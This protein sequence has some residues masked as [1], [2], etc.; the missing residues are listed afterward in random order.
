MG[1]WN[2]LQSEDDDHLLDLVAD[3]L[4]LTPP[5]V[6][7]VAAAGRAAYTWRTVEADLHRCLSQAWAGDVRHR[8]LPRLIL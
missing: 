1:E 4:A 8:L 2:R 3:V 7:D 5:S 6:A